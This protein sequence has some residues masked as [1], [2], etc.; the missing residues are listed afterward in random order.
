MRTRQVTGR[1]DNTVE[2]TLSLC[3]PLTRLP[4]YPQSQLVTIP[5]PFP[6]PPPKLAASHS[7][8]D[9]SG[10]AQSLSF[11]NVVVGSHEIVRH[12]TP[13]V[14]TTASRSYEHDRHN[15]DSSQWRILFSTSPSTNVV[16]SKLHERASPWESDTA[17]N[18]NGSI[19]FSGPFTQHTWNPSSTPNTYAGPCIN[20]NKSSGQSHPSRWPSTPLFSARPWN[21]S[22]CRGFVA[23]DRSITT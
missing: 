4:I 7:E 18:V 17:C 14:L 15:V 9:Y 6:I 5:F 23:L 8:A 21:I 13:T 12:P 22:S 1:R 10:A 19:G 16:S 20:R 11:F 3:I 2:R